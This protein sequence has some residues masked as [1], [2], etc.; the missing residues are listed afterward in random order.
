MMM[1]GDAHVAALPRRRQQRR[2]ALQ[3]T[4]AIIGPSSSLGSAS[5]FSDKRSSVSKCRCAGRRPVKTANRSGRRASPDVR[6]AICTEKRRST[7]AVQQACLGPPPLPPVLPPPLCRL[8]SH[9]H[10]AGGRW[11]HHQQGLQQDWPARKPQ[12]R[13]PGCLPLTVSL[14]LL[15]R[16]EVPPSAGLRAVHPNALLVWGVQPWSPPERLLGGFISPC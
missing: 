13:V 16:G 1:D 4:P 14:Q 5:R 6:Q 3:L 7:A 15:C 11:H 10:P 12:R 2:Q 8:R 9:E